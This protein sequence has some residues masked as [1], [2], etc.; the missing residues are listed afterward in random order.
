VG[1]QGQHKEVTALRA[2]L[3]GLR[4]E[5]VHAKSEPAALAKQRDG[6][7]KELEKLRTKMKD[8][9]ARLKTA[10]QDKNHLQVGWNKSSEVMGMRERC[11]FRLSSGLV[12]AMKMGS[13]GLFH[14]LLVWT[15]N[16]REEVQPRSRLPLL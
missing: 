3:A 15:V 10:V 4:K 13:N 14:V 9:E 6:L 1:T 12:R 2:N 8:S 7:Q 16:Y 5:L 11:D